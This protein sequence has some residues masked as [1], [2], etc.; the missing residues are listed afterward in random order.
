MYQKSLFYNKKHKEKNVQPDSKKQ[1]SVK[2]FMNVADFSYNGKSEG[3]LMQMY[4][5]IFLEKKQK[6]KSFLYPNDL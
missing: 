6:Q 5:L 4:W 3:Q 1:V 2:N